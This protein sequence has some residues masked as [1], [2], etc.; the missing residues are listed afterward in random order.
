MFQAVLFRKLDEALLAK[1]DFED[2]LTSDVFGAFKYLPV[3]YLHAWI[4]RLRDRHPLLTPMT[5]LSH[6][7]AEPDY[8]KQE[9]RRQHQAGDGELEVSREKESNQEQE[10][11]RLLDQ[12]HD[13]VGDCALH[14]QD[15]VH[16]ST[17]QFTRWMGGVKAARLGQHLLI[18][19]VAQIVGHSEADPLEGVPADE[20]RQ[21][22]RQEDSDDQER[23]EVDDIGL[24]DPESPLEALVAVVQAILELEIGGELLQA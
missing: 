6:S 24:V 13:P 21:A 23:Q 14:H 16:D 5:A 22:A 11:Q 18:Q 2:I 4:A 19:V 12:I 15:I 7:G 8:R 3:D 9:D 20:V 17:D 10:C 1:Q